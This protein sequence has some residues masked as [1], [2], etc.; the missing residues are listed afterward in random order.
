MKIKT[1]LTALA[2]PLI[3]SCTPAPALAENWEAI[4]SVKPNE[5]PDKVDVFKAMPMEQQCEGETEW[6]R[7]GAEHAVLGYARGI[8]EMPREY[9]EY[10]EHGIPLPK[11]SMWVMG[12]NLLTP[13]EQD[14]MKKYVF[15]GYDAATAI[16]A[17]DHKITD[18]ELDEMAQTY[19]DKCAYDKT[20]ER[21]RP[22]AEIKGE[23]RFE[24]ITGTLVAS[25]RRLYCDVRARKIFDDC[26]E[27]K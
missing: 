6:F 14:F 16:L 17:K 2:I 8:K 11:D 3:Y 9:M 22:G 10:L 1:L 25:S 15:E 18:E 4:G 23:L 5:E 13:K 27:G 12:W 19:F 20:Q 24:D 26:M 7:D 21:V